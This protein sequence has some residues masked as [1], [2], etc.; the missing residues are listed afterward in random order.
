MILAVFLAAFSTP[1]EARGGC[2]PYQKV[3][4]LLKNKYKEVRI[5][6]GI[7]L[8]EQMIFELWLNK[9]KGTFSALTVNRMGVACIRFPGKSYETFDPKKTGA[10]Y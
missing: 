2:G 4:D 8:N 7:H 3:T 10:V 6:R 9:D 5:Q 1:A